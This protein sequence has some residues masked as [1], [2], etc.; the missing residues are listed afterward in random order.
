[1]LPGLQLVLVCS[2]LL[3]APARVDLRTALEARSPGAPVKVEAWVHARRVMSSSVAFLTLG[4]GEASH[5]LQA[6]LKRTHVDSP[7]ALF[8]QSVRLAAP[9]ARRGES[10]LHRHRQP[11]EVGGLIQSRSSAA[12][13]RSVQPGSAPLGRNPRRDGS[14]PVSG[15]AATQMD[16]HGSSLSS[17][18]FKKGG[19]KKFS[20]L[21]PTGASPE[22]QGYPTVGIM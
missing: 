4:D 21:E 7:P 12:A 10:A 18:I 8:K 17:S 14:P 15:P 22:I 13:C 2:A 11:D 5:D 20:R 6:I 19:W 9:G 3:R 1:M 16:N